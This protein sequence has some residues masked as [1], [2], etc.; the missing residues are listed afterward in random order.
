MGTCHNVPYFMFRRRHLLG[1]KQLNEVKSNV[2]SFIPTGDYYYK[3]AL[4]AIEQEQ[5]DKAYKYL[6]R[7]ME[8]SPDDAQI[9]MQLGIIEM[10]LHHFDIA[11]DLF[12]TAHSLDPNDA[13]IMFFL[14]EA[15]GT[16]G[17]MRDAKKYAE[18]YLALE[19]TGMYAEEAQ[20]IL[21]FVSVEVELPF[22]EDEL[23][24]KEMMAQEKAR[25]LM[26]KGEFPKAI[27]ILEQLIEQKPHFW[28]AYN[29]LALAY[30]YVG[31][32]ED[33]KALL[34]QVL[35]ENKG[36]LHAICN[37]TV[38]AYYEKND[39][40]LQAL[41]E[42]LM[43]I[44]PYVWEHRY[45]LGATLALVGQYE[46]AYKWL[47]SMQKRGY[48]GDAGFYFW[49]A[50]AAYFSGHEEIAKTTWKTLVQLDSSKEGFEPWRDISSVLD[51]T[52]LEHH[53][54]YIIEKL[55]SP[56]TS[57]RIFGLFLLG[58]SP[59]QQEII[60]HPTIIQVESYKAIEK[61]F[62]AHILNHSFD[63][64]NQ[65][66]R[67]F[68]KAFEVAEHLLQR[69]KTITTSLAPLFQMWFALCEQALLQNYDF[70]NPRALAAAAEFLYLTSRMDKVTKKQVAGQYGISVTTLTKYMEEL[71]QYI[72][73]QN[74]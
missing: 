74:K 31:E 71:L 5:M 48:E 26:E 34:H 39:V 46:V 50:H 40:E 22:E 52:N 38:I 61:L 35:R 6:K 17:M 1:K 66:E 33:A 18:K 64:K 60:S 68:L 11:Y 27:E 53:R 7:A 30:F 58:K 51:S 63:E 62:L 69:F 47:R 20:D 3:K 23:E 19:P 36:N 65:I 25:R 54:E 37:L 15:S 28:S 57:D 12:Q 44:Q 49:L 70:K 2:V 16:I 59:Y 29:N 8:L 42:V 72:P 43:K 56:Y 41:L 55:S 21:E 9:L 24:A 4:K 67:K 14:A 32:S 45:K 10:E 73:V 13:E